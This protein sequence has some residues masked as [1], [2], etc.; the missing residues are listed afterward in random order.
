M[1]TEAPEI[2][3]APLG[4]H[5]HTF[6]GAPNT[7]LFERITSKTE[8]M[9]RLAYVRLSWLVQ[10]YQHGSAGDERTPLLTYS[11]PQM[12]QRATEQRFSGGGSR[13][14]DKTISGVIGASLW[15]PSSASDL[16][17]VVLDVR[18][19]PSWAPG[20]RRVE[21]LERHDEPGMVSEWE[22]SLLGL[23]RRF[24]SVLEEAQSPVL[25]RWSYEGLV[26]GWGRCDIREW[27]D[28]A[29]AVFETGLLRAQEPS[30]EKLVGKAAV[31]EAAT[32]HLK[33]CLARLGRTV[34]SG[35]D[36]RRVRVG[37]AEGAGRGGATKRLRVVAA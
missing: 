7:T 6:V 26:R 31:R 32:S 1:S 27:G 22:V 13:V 36:A 35:E 20:V 24:R 10:H 37:P 15:V 17:K 28:G 34:A 8:G 11:S 29:L 25:L 19:F 12:G 30:L 33:R 14:L 16:Y 3:L 4:G 2:V 18:L 23:K 9:G 5:L 21:V